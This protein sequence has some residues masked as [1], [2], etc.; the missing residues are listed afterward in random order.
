MITMLEVTSPAFSENP[1]AALL[2]APLT[3]T[4]DLF[5]VIDYCAALV[6]VLLETDEQTER[7]ALCGR[8]DHA[9]NQLERLCDEELPPHLLEQL[10][11]TAQPETAI[12]DCWQD[13]DMLLDYVQTLTQTLLSNAQPEAT[14]KVLTGLLHDLIYLLVEQLK[15]PLENC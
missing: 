1:T 2:A 9:L 13:T 8:L 10:S 4:A 6:N 3:T 14:A 11:T 12:P 7:M 5:E 15:S